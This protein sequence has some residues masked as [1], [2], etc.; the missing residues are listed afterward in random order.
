MLKKN[1]NYYK[2]YIKLFQKINIYY[3]FLLIFEYY[4]KKIANT[5]FK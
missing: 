4:Y 3:I 5:I 2:S 1:T